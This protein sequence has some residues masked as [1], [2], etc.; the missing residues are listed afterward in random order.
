MLSNI[1]LANEST[2]TPPTLAQLLHLPTTLGN[3]D[4]RYKV[5]EFFMYSCPHCRKLSKNKS[6]A[7]WKQNKINTNKVSFTLIEKAC[8]PNRLCTANYNAG[9]RHR[10]MTFILNTKNS[11][12]PAKNYADALKQVMA[13]INDKKPIEN[14]MPFKKEQYKKAYQACINNI[15]LDKYKTQ[16]N[17]PAAHVKNKVTVVPSFIITNEDG[18][19]IPKEAVL[20]TSQ[21]M[22]ILDTITN[23]GSN[24]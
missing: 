9:I 13:S 17:L 1:T 2:S 22:E 6:F 14:F 7:T 19:V 15:E 23:M 11:E 16:I 20:D 3:K 4:A 24:Q 10:C 18:S 5:S 12:L 8:W 21:F